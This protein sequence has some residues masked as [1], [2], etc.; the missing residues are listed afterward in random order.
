MIDAALRRLVAQR[1]GGHCEYCRLH[2]DHQP[3]VPFHIEHIIARQHGGDDSADNLALSCHRC[4]LHKGTNLTGIDPQTKKTTHLFHPR[5]QRWI[6]HFEIRDG[7]IIGLS[8]IGRTTASLLQM[9]APERIDLR[10]TLEAA[11][12]WDID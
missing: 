12:L 8:D 9:N 11:G 10:V 3:T 6:D 5:R 7:H 4:N 1:A 2:R